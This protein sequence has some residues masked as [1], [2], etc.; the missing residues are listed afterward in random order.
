MKANR[1][2]S[3]TE[4]LSMCHTG[5][6]GMVQELK[7]SAM[8]QIHNDRFRADCCVMPLRND[9][10]TVANQVTGCPSAAVHTARALWLMSVSERDV[11]E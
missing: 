8:L 1:H 6:R 11:S 4:T 10:P 5:Y 7:A 3:V 9:R 2:I